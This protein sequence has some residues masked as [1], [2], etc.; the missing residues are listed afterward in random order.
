M[1]ART[2]SSTAFELYLRRTAIYA[3]YDELQFMRRIAQ[4][5]QA[6]LRQSVAVEAQHR[7]QATKQH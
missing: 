1:L 2:P 6:G 7:M 5:V 3:I 4:T